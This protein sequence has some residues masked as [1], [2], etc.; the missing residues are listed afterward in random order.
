MNRVHKDGSMIFHQHLLE[1]GAPP[2]LK[3][4]KRDSIFEFL[5]A[6]DLEFP[7]TAKGN[8]D[9]ILFSVEPQGELVLNGDVI[10]EG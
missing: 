6:L 1:A 4:R 7:K 3:L 5:V 8:V 2:K 10:N 9:Q